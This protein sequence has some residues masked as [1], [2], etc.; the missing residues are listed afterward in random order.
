[1][2]SVFETWDA[3]D[4]RELVLLMRKFADAMQQEPA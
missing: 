1:M 2:R 3:N 4:V